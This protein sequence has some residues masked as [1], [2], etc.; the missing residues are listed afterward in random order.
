LALEK[1]I[2]IDVVTEPSVSEVVLDPVRFKQV[3]YNYLSNAIKF[4]PDDGRVTVRISREDVG[5]FRIEVEDT[6]IGIQPDDIRK[7][8]IEFQQLDTGTA[9]RYP[10]TGL[11]L[12]LTKRIVEAQGGQLGVRSAVGKGSTFW[13]SLPLEGHRPGG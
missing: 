8:F 3:L 7:L 2:R 10:G 11:G 13:A 4:T 12:A 1:S 6:G 5:T 9:K